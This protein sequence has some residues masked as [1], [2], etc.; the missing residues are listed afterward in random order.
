M[1]DPATPHAVKLA[2]ARDL[3][4]RNDLTAK[5]VEVTVKPWDA[6]LGDIVIDSDGF[7]TS[8][9][10]V[11]IDGDVQD[12][13]ELPPELVTLPGDLLATRQA[14]T[15]DSR[16]PRCLDPNGHGSARSGGSA[17]AGFE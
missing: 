16:P 10:P 2:A 17:P 6:M 1:E 7:E 14:A 12:D 9:L 3:L 8:A 15:T 5:I 13:R 11:A 4:D